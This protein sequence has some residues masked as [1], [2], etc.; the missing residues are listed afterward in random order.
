MR[1]W[2]K[3][4]RRL[5]S[6]SANYWLWVNQYPD[7]AARA[8]VRIPK[9]GSAKKTGDLRRPRSRHRVRY[10]ASGAAAWSESCGKNGNSLG[11][12]RRPNPR[13]VRRIR[14]GRVSANR[15]SR[16]SGAGSGRPRRRAHRPGAIPGC[17]ASAVECRWRPALY[18]LLAKRLVR[19]GLP[20][21]LV[22]TLQDLM[23]DSLYHLLRILE[24][25]LRA[26]LGGRGIPRRRDS[27]DF[28][29]RRRSI[30]SI[31]CLSSRATSCSLDAATSLSV[32]PDGGLT[33]NTSFSGVTR[34]IPARTSS[35]NSSSMALVSTL[36][37]KSGGCDSG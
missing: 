23:R 2:E 29:A 24:E 9:A 27:A 5:P 7:H 33:G 1:P 18:H 30:H 10:R 14:S 37:N 3:S 13:L 26:L 28:C 25:S 12:R 35:R 21:H 34:R 15:R 16:V 19:I 17:A 36:E 6:S 11:S 4:F 31:S 8:V 20:V 32:R 22:P